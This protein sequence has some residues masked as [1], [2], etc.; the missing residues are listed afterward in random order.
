MK[1]NRE[2]EKGEKKIIELGNYLIVV[3]IVYT[4]A[5]NISWLIV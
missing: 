3:Y 1:K 4:Q 5:S 2:N